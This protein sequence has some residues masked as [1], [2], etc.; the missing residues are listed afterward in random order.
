MI[1]FLSLLDASQRLL[2]YHSEL[3]WRDS[4]LNFDFKMLKWD[5]DRLNS[6]GQVLYSSPSSNAF[7]PG[8]FHCQE[9]H[10]FLK[11]CL[12]R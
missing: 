3:L 11:W 7:I 9:L 1:L 12:F 4:L 2:N 8:Y 5:K 10:S 6:H